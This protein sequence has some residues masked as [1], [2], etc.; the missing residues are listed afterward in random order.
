MSQSPLNLRQVDPSQ[1]EPGRP[2]IGVHYLCAGKYIRV[3]RSSDGSR[4][5]T[6]C[7]QCSRCAVFRVGEG[8]S[9]SRQFEVSCR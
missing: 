1:P 7:P 5:H 9:A 4:Y 6:R 3:Y 2:W 8:G